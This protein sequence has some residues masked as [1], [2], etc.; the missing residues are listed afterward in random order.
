[1]KLWIQTQPQLNNTLDFQYHVRL[2][3]YG[4]DMNTVNTNPKASWNVTVHAQKPEFVFRQKG[5]VHL[6]RQGCQFSR[7]LAAV[8][9]VSAL[10]MLDTPRSEVVWE[11]WL[12]TPFASFPFTSPPVRHRVPSGFKRTL[13]MLKQQWMSLLIR[14]FFRNLSFMC[15]ELI[16]MFKILWLFHFLSPSHTLS[17]HRSVASSKTSSADSAI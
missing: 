10:A 17:Y 11:Y 3:A 16:I 2:P 14:R 8:V 4:T 6:N 12:P 9:C 13:T 1:M 7:I 15:A 5:R